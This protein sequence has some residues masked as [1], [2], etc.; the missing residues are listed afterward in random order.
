MHLHGP[1]LP[2]A[3]ETLFLANLMLAPGLAFV[4]L[5][6]LYLVKI[7]TADSLAANHLSQ[8]FC[9][10][11]LG[12]ILIV[13]VIGLVLMPGSRDSAYT[14]MVV[15]LYFTCVHSSLILM[16]MS[17]LVKA[18]NGQHFRYPLLGRLCRS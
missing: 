12:G 15:I 3:A 18:L 13:P 10:S 7:Q 8:T 5:A 16:G 14:W 6:F 1:P 9:V 11:L 17:G 4:A 2:I